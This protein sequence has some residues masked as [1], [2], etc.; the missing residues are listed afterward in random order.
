MGNEY[1]DFFKKKVE[2]R[3]PRSKSVRLNPKKKNKKQSTTRKSK[4]EFPVAA[5]LVTSLGVIVG[6]WASYDIEKVEEWIDAVEVGVYSKSH[7]QTKGGEEKSKPKGSDEANTSSVKDVAKQETKAKKDSWT[8]EEVALFKKLDE[9]KTKLDLREAELVKLEEEL[10]R[11]KGM[12]EERMKELDQVRNEIAGQLQ[13]RVEVDQ[14]RVTKLVDV[15]SNMKPLNAAKVFEKLDEDLAIEVLG[16]M[17]KKSA[18]DILN[19]LSSDKAQRLSE[20]YAGY[21]RR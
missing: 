2:Q 14:Q 13:D 12:L 6:L 5:V 15:Y 21:K 16:N 1:K 7:A 17:K 3:R 11:Q 10:Q 20:K 4:Y 9:R 8:P 19:L 18:A